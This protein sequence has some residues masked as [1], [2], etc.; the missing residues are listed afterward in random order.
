MKLGFPMGYCGYHQPHCI[1]NHGGAQIPIKIPNAE[2]LCMECYAAGHKGTPKA[3]GMNKV[4][5]V[6]VAISRLK[7]AGK[8][9]QA[10]GGD[11]A[12][13]KT[14][15][16]DD[17]SSLDSGYSRT[18]KSVIT[19]RSQGEETSLDKTAEHTNNNGRSAIRENLCKWRPNPEEM[20]TEKKLYICKCEP[21]WDADA[22]K[23]YAFC[24]M[25]LTNCVKD[26]ASGS[27]A[28][29]EPNIYG[30]CTMHHISI[31]GSAPEPVK[32]PYPGMEL[33]VNP[34]AP[35]KHPLAPRW[36]KPADIVL[37]DAPL[38]LV[39]FKKNMSWWEQRKANQLYER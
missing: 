14:H 27:A 10:G 37:E 12:F 25:H 36:E 38:S 26:H 5:G 32:F 20:K 31:I 6:Y 24:A 4:P 29:E 17:A 34:R 30:L 13:D 2:A 23:K 1:R 11:A 21:F 35:K 39:H 7:K 15:R 18:T 16:D 22:N 8:S 9:G 3:I 28:I 33:R 19:T